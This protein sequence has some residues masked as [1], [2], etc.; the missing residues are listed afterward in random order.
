METKEG[1]DTAFIDPGKPWQNGTSESFNGRLRDECL[2]VEWFR[3]RR[4]AKAITRRGDGTTTTFGL[5]RVWRLDAERGQEEYTDSDRE[6]QVSRN[7]WSSDLKAGT[8]RR[9]SASLRLP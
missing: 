2:G 9:A 6:R 3:S 8:S 7:R 1:I 4:E 5:T